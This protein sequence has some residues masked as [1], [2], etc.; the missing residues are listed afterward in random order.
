[1]KRGLLILVTLIGV[2]GSS[3]GTAYAATL[4]TLSYWYSDSSEINRWGGTSRTIWSGMAD[5]SISTTTFASYVNHATTQW[6]SAGISTEGVNDLSNARIRV[7]GGSYNTLKAMEPAIDSTTSAYTAYS[8]RTLEG[9]WK[10]GT[11]L[12]TGYKF[13]GPVNIYIVQLGGKTT[14]AY[15]KTV[16]H[17][18]GH[19][20]GW[21]GHS[22]NSSDVMYSTSSEIINLTTRDKN[23][24]IQVY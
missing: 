22:S 23:H 11:T 21:R 20:L 15:K 6:S 4:G 24:L 18:L 19:A 5:S 13:S 7:H 12:K 16:T 8:G 2:V 17:E 10:Y 9:D 1:M 3:L 14:N